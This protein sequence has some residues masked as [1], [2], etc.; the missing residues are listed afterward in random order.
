M[1]TRDDEYSKHPIH[2][3]ER[4]AQMNAASKAKAI[5]AVIDATGTDGGKGSR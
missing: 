2:S 3:Q 4:I 1:P 5:D